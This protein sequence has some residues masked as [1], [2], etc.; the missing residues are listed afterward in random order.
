MN[1]LACCKVFF[2][3]ATLEGVASSARPTFPGVGRNA[4]PKLPALIG[5]ANAV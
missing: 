1:S 2:F 3:Q 5:K 4:T